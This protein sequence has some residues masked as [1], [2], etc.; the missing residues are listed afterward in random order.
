[1]TPLTC[2]EVILDYLSDYLDAQLSAELT[3]GLERH[4]AGCPSCLAYLNTYGRTLEMVGKTMR[5]PMPE[6]MRA[7]LR[8]FV[9]RRLSGGPR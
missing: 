1:M 7:I 3:K 5:A 4:L 2:K 9:L 6:E 8:E